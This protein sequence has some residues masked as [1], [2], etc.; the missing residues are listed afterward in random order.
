M[1]KLLNADVISL[2]L[3]RAHKKAI[4][5]LR[6]GDRLY[7]DHPQG[8]FHTMKNFALYPRYSLKYIIDNGVIVFK[9]HGEFV[10]TDL[11]RT[12]NTD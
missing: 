7:Y 10:L 6:N 12:I 4:I 9:S 8:T 5:A 11:G 1:E 2:N 3:S